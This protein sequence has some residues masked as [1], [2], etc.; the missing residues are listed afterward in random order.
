MALPEPDVAQ[1]KNINASLFDLCK[2]C[3]AIVLQSG[4]EDSSTWDVRGEVPLKMSTTQVLKSGL[5]HPEK[6]HDKTGTWTCSYSG[7]EIHYGHMYY[8][9]H[10]LNMT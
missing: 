5:K 6:S 2:H 9:L 4:V 1:G 10:R 3:G 7:V 8:L